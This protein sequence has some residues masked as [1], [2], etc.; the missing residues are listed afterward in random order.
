MGFEN[1]IFNP[2]Q[3]EQ[4][5]NALREKLE[6]LDVGAEIE[7]L[8]ARESLE[9]KKSLRLRITDSEKWGSEE[10]A[11]KLATYFGELAWQAYR[12]DPKNQ[13]DPENPKNQ[14]EAVED[15]FEGDLS[16]ADHVY[17]IHEGE[18]V[19][20]FLSTE[21]VELDEGKRGCLIGLNV[22]HRGERNQG[23]GKELYGYVFESGEYRAVMGCSNTPAAVKAR[24]ET[25]KQYGYTG[26][27]GG[28]REGIYGKQ[29]T[30]EQMEEMQKLSGIM[31]EI[32]SD[33]GSTIPLEE[34]PE[35]TIVVRKDIGPIPPLKEKDIHFRP[36][37]EGLDET[38]RK[39]LLPAQKK[40]LPHTT[41]G[42]LLNIREKID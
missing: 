22:V 30:P 31:Q 35:H 18:R 27:Y 20:A 15:I 3:P 39:W 16:E 4:E 38:F 29:G 26:Y 14:K 37:E 33:A 2:I 11:K 9:G 41:Y 7:E 24:L 25:G 5:K 36:E 32:Y 19:L 28:H 34:M 21:D 17:V 23:L 1:S 12:T 6:L 8:P 10:S 13:F 40:H 42:I